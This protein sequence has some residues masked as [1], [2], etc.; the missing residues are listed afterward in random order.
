MA[1]KKLSELATTA[2][3]ADA[4]YLPCVAGGATKTI[5]K[6]N[7]K[8]ALGGGGDWEPLDV[9]SKFIATVPNRRWNGSSFVAVSD[10]A[11]GS[12]S[13]GDFVKP[14]VANGFL[15]E[16]VAAGTSAVSEPSWGTTSGSDTTDGTVSWRC[17]RWGVIET[18]I[19]LTGS[20]KVGMPIRYAYSGGTLYGVAIGVS[21]SYV[22]IA[23]PGMLS[24]V[25]LTA[26]AYG[27][28]DR[29]RTMH[30]AVPGDYGASTTDILA[31]VANQYYTWQHA[32]AHLVQFDVRHKTNAGTTQ[33]KVNP[34]LGG[35]LVSDN[36]GNAGVSTSTSR[37]VNPYTAINAT[38]GVVEKDEAIELAVT[39]ASVGTAVAHLS[40]TLVF[41]LE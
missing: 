7:L 24:N 2:T 16:C 38:N 23:G 34:R 17:R 35:S 11:S 28:A 4:D 20:I 14:T 21:S 6:V 19:D 5:T 12:Y 36:D 39:A 9:T 8:A 31:A 32:K 33:P 25:A 10:W 18:A 27:S 30:L 40:S 13:V 15:Y 22:A 3:L 1:D 41:V 29:V 37:V 26:V